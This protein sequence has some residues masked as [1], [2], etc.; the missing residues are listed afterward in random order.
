MIIITR[1]LH[2]WL[3]HDPEGLELAKQADK[4]AGQD[5]DEARRNGRR[6]KQLLIK[7]H[8]SERFIREI[9]EKHT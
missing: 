2:W 9:R 8:L 7:N 5:L 6:A 4:Q 1:F 3:H